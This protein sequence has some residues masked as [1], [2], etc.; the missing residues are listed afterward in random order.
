VDP[1]IAAYCRRIEAYLCQKNDGHLVRVVGP[2]FE[3]VSRWAAD[4][5]PVKVAYRGIDR[6]FERYYR[7]GPRRRPVRIE[8]CEADVRDV[9][10]EWR[11]AIGLADQGGASGAPETAAAADTRAPSLPR[12]LERAVLRLSSARATGALGEGAD[13][14]IDRVVRELDGVRASGRSTRGESR[15][16][17]LARLAALDA[18]L[19][20][21]ARAAMT[22]AERMA[23]D[24]S[25]DE[26]LAAFRERMP[27]EAYARARTALADRLVRERLGLPTLTLP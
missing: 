17:L 9:F 27:G 12:H 24:Q 23:I 1:E 6:Y 20:A 2:S 5:V 19:L 14:L 10:D 15:Q 3:V 13:A 25:A 11:R 4:G 26:E 16:A 22:D 7:K 8:F 21:T 18:E